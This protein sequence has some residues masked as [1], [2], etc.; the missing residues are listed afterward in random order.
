MNKIL[1]AMTGH[2]NSVSCQQWICLKKYNVWLTYVQPHQ[3][4]LCFP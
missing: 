4:K 3:V 2:H 1:I